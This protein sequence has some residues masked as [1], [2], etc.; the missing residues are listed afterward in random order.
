[1]ENSFPFIYCGFLFEWFRPFSIEA[2]EKCKINKAPKPSTRTYCFKRFVKFFFFHF[3]LASIM[4]FSSFWSCYVNVKKFSKVWTVW[5][6]QI[7]WRVH[8]HACTYAVEVINFLTRHL[9]QL[10]R[11]P[12]NGE[13]KIPQESE[14]RPSNR[15]LLGFRGRNSSI[16]HFFFFWKESRI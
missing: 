10:P 5:R 4:N 16:Q 13:P 2:T 15:F 6:Y 8:S 11:Y 7:S 14:I 3:S 9:H 1:M 12:I